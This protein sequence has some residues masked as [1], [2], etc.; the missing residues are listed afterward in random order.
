MT[1]GTRRLEVWSR[2]FA[3]PAA[4]ADGSNARAPGVAPLADMLNSAADV[5]RF[6]G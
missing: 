5:T 3:L 6:R 4:E 2:S 1:P